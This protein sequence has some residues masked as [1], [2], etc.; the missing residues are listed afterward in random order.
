MRV[1]FFTLGCKVN[2]NDTQGI[3]EVFRGQ[4]HEIVPFEVGAEVYVINTCTV[5][6]VGAQ[7]SRQVIRRAVKLNPDAIVVVTG[8]YAQIAGNEILQIPGVNLVVGM[9]DWLRLPELVSEFQLKRTNQNL[10]SKK[11]EL[12][13]WFELPISTVETRTRATLKIEDGCDQFCSYCIVPYARGGVRSMPPELVKKEFLK[14]LQQGYHEIVLTGIHLGSYGK[15]LGIKLF[16]LLVKLLEIPGAYRLRLGSIEPL[17]FDLNLLNLIP[18]HSKICQHVHVPLQSGHNRILKLMNRGYDLEYYQQ[19][20][21]RLREKNPLISIGTD[22]I[23]GFPS[24]T[25]LEF[26]EIADFVKTQNFSKIHIFK[27]SPREGTKAATFP[28]RIPQK[29]QE[30]RARILQQI[31]AESSSKYAAS[32]VGKEVEVIFEEQIAGVWTGLSSEYLR[33]N[34]TAK[35]IIPN[36]LT[37]IIVSESQDEKLQG[38]LAEILLS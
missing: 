10:V 30:Q 1:A 32:F 25:E 18:N 24:E 16:D 22:L 31:E 26:E 8:C 28:E 3:M 4:G 20:L 19:L 35:A 34:S 13:E 37:K 12:T 5:T 6:G 33:V 21:E 29:I 14:L 17:D 36:C 15:D 2:Q 27:Y 7:K 9:T 38:T 11:N 23:L